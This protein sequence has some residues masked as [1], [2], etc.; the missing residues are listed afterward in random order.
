M[1]HKHFLQFRPLG[2]VIFWNHFTHN[3]DPLNPQILQLCSI[4][5]CTCVTNHFFPSN[6]KGVFQ[7]DFGTLNVTVTLNLDLPPS[8]ASRYKNNLLT[9]EPYNMLA[10]FENIA[11]YLLQAV[12]IPFYPFLH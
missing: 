12:F 6:S 1:L 9:T 7:T 5:H 2:Q 4:N 3:F 11:Y 8:L 10:L